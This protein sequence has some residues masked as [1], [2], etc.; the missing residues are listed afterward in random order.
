MYAI[1][2]QFV[3]YYTFGTRIVLPC[4][5]SEYKNLSDESQNIGEA[6]T[7]DLTIRLKRAR[8]HKLEVFRVCHLSRRLMH[9]VCYC[10]SSQY[11]DR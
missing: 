9:R 10:A 5:R 6:M 8:A 11:G 7:D 3:K 2:A 1:L 4:V